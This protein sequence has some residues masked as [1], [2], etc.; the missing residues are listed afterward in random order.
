MIEDVDT[1]A[2]GKRQIYENGVDTSSTNPVQAGIKS[3]FTFSDERSVSRIAKY[4]F[5]Y[6]S[7]DRIVGEDENAMFHNFLNQNVF[8]R[9][10]IIFRPTNTSSTA[11]FHYVFS[12]KIQEDLDYANWL[13]SRKYSQQWCDWHADYVPAN[14]GRM[15]ASERNGSFF[16]RNS[17]AWRFLR[18]WSIHVGC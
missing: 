11:V 14:I 17:A 1:A 8:R 12:F 9:S 3:R 13:E 7:I 10:E 5:E 2:I 15:C 18:N 16:D 4:A 6:S